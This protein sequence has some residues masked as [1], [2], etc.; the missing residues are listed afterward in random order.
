[1]NKLNQHENFLKK[2]VFFTETKWPH[3][4]LLFNDIKKLSKVTKKNSCVVSLERN[5]LYGGTSLFAPFFS[6]HN[7]VSV[8]CITPELKKRGKYNS[9][10]I[11]DNNKIIYYKRNYQFDY[12]KI[13]LKSNFADLI[14]IPNLMHHINDVDILLHQ[15]KRI[16]KKGGKIY[17]FEPMV[18]ELH[19]IPE[20][21]FRI[22]PYGF[23]FL[24]KKKKF[25]N[26]KIN[27]D[28]GP[29]TAIIYCW[30][31]SLQYLP[32]NIMKKKSRWLEKN[33]PKLRLL[34]KKYKKNLLRK[35]TSFP[36][37]YSLQANL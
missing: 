34:D 24:L 11:V 37:S 13:K 36:M 29:F 32:K 25:K 33:I 10:N 4:N 15:A 19:Q 26:F 23:K 18:R 7:F 3:F 1:M 20:D 30:D 22:T 2:K 16:L 8:D 31:Q 17:I 21:Y 35:R 27:F 5:N 12:R 28:G 14:I 6:K 9:K